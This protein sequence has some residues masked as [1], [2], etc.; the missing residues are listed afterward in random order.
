M[1][2][3][4]PYARERFLDIVRHRWLVSR[5]SYSLLIVAVCSGCFVLA[6][7]LPAFG[8]IS[9]QE[10]VSFIGLSYE[11]VIRHLWL[12]QFL[13]APLLHNGIAHLLFNMLTL[14]MLG[15]SIEAKLGRASYVGFS[16]FCALCSM[17]GFLAFNWGSNRIILGYSGIIFGILVLQAY[18]YPNNII[19]VF[20]I[21]PLRM[22]Y[23]VILMALIELYLLIVPESGGIAHIAHLFGAAAACVYVFATRLSRHESGELVPTVPKAQNSARSRL[24]IKGRIPDEL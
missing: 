4:S 16:L 13:T 1:T 6:A 12:H 8:V 15:P 20:A 22:K 17:L 2:S 19:M 24:R 18:F 3:H 21:F 9:R 10:L 11:G 14:W 23:A 7:M 5:G